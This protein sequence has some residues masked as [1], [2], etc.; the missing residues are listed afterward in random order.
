MPHH[1]FY[2]PADLS[3]NDEVCL[4]G[5]EGNHLKVMRVAK[6]DSVELINGK[7]IL[8][9]AKV[10]DI[11]KNKCHLRVAENYSESP[12]STSITLLQ[13]LPKMNR[14]DTILEKVTELG[15]TEIALFPGDRSEKNDLS[16][17]QYQRVL[18]ILIAATKQSGRLFLPKIQVLPPIEKWPT[19]EGSLLF[20]DIRPGAARLLDVLEKTHSQNVYF[21][22]GPEAGLS[23]RE[24]NLLET[25]GFKG[26]SLHRNVLRTDTAPIAALAI[27][28]QFF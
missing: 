1:R 15:V 6:G 11:S 27:I 24:E 16:A 13:A 22:V 26:V 18:S 12:P 9:H 20:G 14:L 8:A 28:S 5:D 3:L 21:C 19:F 25:K 2:T 17:Q 10:I 7:G 23:D 4:E